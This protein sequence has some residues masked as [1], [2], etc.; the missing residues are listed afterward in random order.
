MNLDNACDLYKE[1]IENKLCGCSYKQRL[2]KIAENDYEYSLGNCYDAPKT[3]NK[4]E[5]IQK[6]LKENDL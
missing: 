3:S 4:F 1:M 6:I 5:E 2:W